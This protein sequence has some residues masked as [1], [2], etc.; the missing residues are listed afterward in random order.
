MVGSISECQAV[1][2]VEQAQ[3][4]GID[5]FALNVVTSTEAWSNNAIKALFDAAYGTGFKLFFSFDMSRFASPTDA[6]PL[7]QQWQSNSSYYKPNGI[8]YTSTFQGGTKTFGY[9][10]PNAG[11]QAKFKDALAS[12]AIPTFF[13]PAFDDSP[14]DPASF[15]KTFPVVDGLFAWENSW[16]LASAG[17]VN[18]SSARDQAYLTA[19]KAAGKKYMM[20]ISAVQYKHM[21]INNNRYR[22][23]GLNLA[24]RIPQILSLGPDY[25]QI[26]T[27]NDAGESQYIGPIWPDAVGGT[28]INTYTDNYD[29]S[30]WQILLTPFIKA[31]KAGIKDVSLV[32]PTGSATVQGVFW[33]STLLSTATCKNDTIGPPCGRENI[34]DTINVAVLVAKGVTG[35]KVLVYSGGKQVA[36]Y[37]AVQGLNA[38]EVPGLVVGQVKVVVVSAAGV[39]LISGTGPINVLADSN[40]CNYNPQVVPLK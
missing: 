33:H 21:N 17:K 36:T 23:G 1:T 40:I 20:G 12:L 4:M 24:L 35:V 22:R 3:A 18:V 29:H 11:W 30:G 19:A 34:Q 15:F 10:T 26:Q 39:T 38:W 13:V 2:D 9:T 27:W 28:N 32:V 6:I 31:Y 8:A 7:L 37:A 16:P 25:V 14:V 5:A